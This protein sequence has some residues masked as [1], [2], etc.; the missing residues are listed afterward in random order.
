MMIHPTAIIHPKAEIATDVKIG[1]Y[2]IIGENVRI[3]SGNKIGPHVNIDGM[4]SIGKNNQFY[5]YTSIGCEP[6]DKKYEGEATQ[7]N[8]GEGN[9]F[10]EYITV[11]TGTIQDQGMTVIGDHNWFMATVHIAH[12]CQVGSHTVFANNAV[13][14]GH[15]KVGDWAVISAG[16]LVHQFVV[17]GEHVIISGNTGVTQDIP[18]YVI[19]QGYRAEP[20]GVNSEGLRRRGFSA[21]AI[22]EIKRTYKLI[23]RQNM[24]LDE[25]IATITEK[26]QTV[27]ELDVFV[28]FFAESSRGLIR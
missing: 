27:P 4:T 17:I 15:V 16:C 10:R 7:L 12:D 19:A 18:P 6:Q 5:A 3:D 20:Y 24:P 26:A 8:I 2:S 1:P 25:A 14:A 13:L 11:S 9:T 23:Y 28:R 21:A 22:S